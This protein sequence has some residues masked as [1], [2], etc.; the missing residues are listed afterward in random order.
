M[1][2]LGRYLFSEE[3]AA[4]EG[5]NTVIAKEPY[6]DVGQFKVLLR[7]DTECPTVDSLDL[8]LAPRGN[9]QT[10]VAFPTKRHLGAHNIDRVNCG[11]PTSQEWG[12]GGGRPSRNSGTAVHRDNYSGARSP[13]A[14]EY[15][16]SSWRA[17]D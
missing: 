6:V 7:K 3:T 9:Y 13:D 16:F 8:E 1:P 2:G 14:T 15:S 4:L 17:P 11:L 5:V 10:K 12:H